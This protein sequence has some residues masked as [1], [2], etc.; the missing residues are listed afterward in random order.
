LYFFSENSWNDQVNEDEIGRAHSVN[1]D[2]RKA[3]G[4]LVRNPERKATRK[5]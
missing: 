2:K 3:Y 5:N 1:R 4:I